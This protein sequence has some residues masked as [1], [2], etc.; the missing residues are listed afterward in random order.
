MS[1]FRIPR[2]DFT[3]QDAANLFRTTQAGQDQ[4]PTQEPTYPFN[5]A[6]A[7]DYQGYQAVETN[8]QNAIANRAQESAAAYAYPNS[9]NQ[10]MSAN[11]T[12]GYPTGT[13]SGFQQLGMGNSYQGVNYPTPA[14]Y[15]M[16]SIPMYG[17][18][19]G[20]HSSPVQYGIQ[21]QAQASNASN[22]LN[23]A[24]QGNYYQTDQG[25][26]DQMSTKLLFSVD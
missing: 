14:Q 7:E 9:Y 6:T 21:A 8:Q 4:S 15:G 24:S 11:N 5:R 26:L 18:T 17:R 25:R 23:F 13:A 2:S 10:Q 3:G 19:G 16:S 22:M 1:C 20:S 12:T